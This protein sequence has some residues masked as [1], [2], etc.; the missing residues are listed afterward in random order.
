MMDAVVS[1]LSAASY[2][3]EYTNGIRTAIIYITT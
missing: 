1:R 3:Q 2:P